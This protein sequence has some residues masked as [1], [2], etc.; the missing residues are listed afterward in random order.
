MPVLV[1]NRTVSARGYQA[2]WISAVPLST[3]AKPRL[4]VDQG[5]GPGMI[6]SVAST[7]G[8]HSPTGVAAT[9]PMVQYQASS[10]EF[11]GRRPRQ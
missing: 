8:D 1:V 7:K 4:Q 6:A 10:V 9:L 11:G 5:P 3:P 2:N